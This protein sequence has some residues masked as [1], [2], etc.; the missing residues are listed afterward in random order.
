MNR[1]THEYEITYR[2]AGPELDLMDDLDELPESPFDEE[3]CKLPPREV[4]T[5]EVPFESARAALLAD[6]YTATDRTFSHPDDY[7]DSTA[8]AG[9]AVLRSIIL[10]CSIFSCGQVTRTWCDRS[11]H[12]VGFARPARFSGYR[13]YQEDETVALALT[14]MLFGH[15]TDQQFSIETRD[16]IHFCGWSQTPRSVDRLY[17]SLTCL[18]YGRFELTNPNF[19]ANRFRLFDRLEVRGSR[20]TGKLSGGIV[21]LQDRNGRGTYIPLERRKALREGLQTWLAGWVLGTTCDKPIAL[22]T[23]HLL[24]G[25][26]HSSLGEFGRDVRRS[27]DR[28]VDV[29]LVSS[30]TQRPNGRLE[31][32]M[33]TIRKARF[34]R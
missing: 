2:N 11:V 5:L 23:L 30:W 26:G 22:Q 6:G 24:S 19:S 33:I 34:I 13:A 9:S 12:P 15:C 32:N 7:L 4:R 25:S 1:E 10:R 8:Y 31:R 3:P 17:S 20:I 28:L 18:A 27:L 21:E 29:G 16:W 14:P